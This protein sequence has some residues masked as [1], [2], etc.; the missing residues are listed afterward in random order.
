MWLYDHVD[1]RASVVFLS[2]KQGS[3]VAK[4][5]VTMRFVLTCREDNNVLQCR[6]TKVRSEVDGRGFKWAAGPRCGLYGT[7]LKGVS[8]LNGNGNGGVVESDGELPVRIPSKSGAILVEGSDEVVNGK[9]SFNRRC[10]DS[11]ASDIFYN[12]VCLQGAARQM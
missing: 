4:D 1:P 5:D 6:G 7:A 2:V 9:I 8:R 12:P 10:K 3:K 11:V